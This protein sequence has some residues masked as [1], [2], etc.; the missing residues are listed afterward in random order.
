MDTEAV[1]RA[2]GDA[3]NESMPDTARL[4]R[5]PPA[6]FRA[7]WVANTEVD[8]GC[9]I[10]KEGDVDATIDEVDALGVGPIADLGIA[11]YRNAHD[12]PSS[13]WCSVWGS[14]DGA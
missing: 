3:G 12:A 2:R 13:H 8:R 10:C 5:Q 4:I 11:K 6:S 14:L 1:T 7:V 9:V